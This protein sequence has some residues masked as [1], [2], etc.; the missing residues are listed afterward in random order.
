M[1]CSLIRKRNYL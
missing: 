1:H